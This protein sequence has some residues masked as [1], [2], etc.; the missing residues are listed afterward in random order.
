MTNEDPGRETR[1]IEIKGRQVVVRQLRDAQMVLL[2][3]EAQMLQRDSVPT[4]RKLLSIT[5]LMDVLESA[6][7]Q[8]SDRD[9]LTELNIAG[10][11][12]LHDLLGVVRAFGKE[13]EKAKP[14]VRRGRPRKATV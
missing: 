10:D 2:L 11:L 13:E 7:V 4:E 9:Y 8:E 14:A 5:R 1:L 12:E 3:R 6:V